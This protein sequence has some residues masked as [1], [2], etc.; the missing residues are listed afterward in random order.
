[1]KAIFGFFRKRWV[2]TLLGLI[3]LS[4]LIWFVGPLFAFAE[5]KPLDPQS[6]R[7]ILIGLVF[8]IWLAR[9]AWGWIK[10]LRAN[11]SLLSGLV[12]S[13]QTAQPSEGQRASAEEVSEL[14]RRMQDALGILKKMRVK[15]DFGTRYVYQLPWYV[16]IG[17]PGAGKTTALLNSGLRFPLAERLGPQAV[18]GVGGTRNCDWWFTDDAVLLDTAGRYTTQDSDRE[19]DKA[20][21]LGFLELLKRHR[22]RRPINGAL[23][24]ISL[25]DLVRQTP[26]ERERHASEIRQRLQELHQSLGIRFPVYVLFTK[27][28]LFA[29]FVEFFGDLNREQLAQV[30]GVTFPVTVG[31]QERVARERFHLVKKDEILYRYDD[32]ATESKR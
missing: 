30:W 3:L 32:S 28:D 1:M 24:A 25:P 4:L 22:G 29:G 11:R 16:I 10:H 5:Y 20:A 19:V 15:G 27:C 14:R 17:A 18:R 7:W 21:W 2:L 6:R 23:V 31:Q 26:S 8:A 12:G 13:G 9:L